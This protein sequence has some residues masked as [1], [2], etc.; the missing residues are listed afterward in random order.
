M[1]KH[2]LFRSDKRLRIL[3]IL[4]SVS[5]ALSS[6]IDASRIL[7]SFSMSDSI[8]SVLLFEIGSLKRN[9]SESFSNSFLSVTSEH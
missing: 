5:S 6:V 3:M 2:I 4:L 8:G 1:E 7:S 9:C